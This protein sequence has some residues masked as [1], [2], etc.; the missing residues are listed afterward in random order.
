MNHNNDEPQPMPDKAWGGKREAGPWSR[1]ASG[2]RNHPSAIELGALNPG[3]KTRFGW[4]IECEQSCQLASDQPSRKDFALVGSAY[5]VKE[6]PQMES[7]GRMSKWHFSLCHLPMVQELRSTAV[8]SRLWAF[9][10]KCE[11]AVDRSGQV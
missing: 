7:L 9:E 10:A 5:F 6:L 4:G 2:L 8:P 3:P 11:A 1:S